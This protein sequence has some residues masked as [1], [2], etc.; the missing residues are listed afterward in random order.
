MRKKTR[1]FG[2][3]DA[4]MESKRFKTR[5]GVNQCKQGTKTKKVG[6]KRGERQKHVSTSGGTEG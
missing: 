4:K 1:M 6:L 5:N 2:A 3:R